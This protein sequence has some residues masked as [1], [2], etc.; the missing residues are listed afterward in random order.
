M[1]ILFLTD[2]FP[3]EVNAPAS[4]T[5]EHCREWVR[6]GNQVT[7]ITCAPNFPT[8][9]VYPGYK[10][11]L[12]QTEMMEGI[13]VIRVWT[14]ITA[15]EG[16]AKRILDYVSYMVAA[17]SAS[18]FV[19]KPDLVIGTSP[20]LFTVMAA[21]AVGFLKRIP[22]VF[23]L[24]DI[25]P[26]SIKAVGAMSDSVVI[27]FFEKIEMFLYRK[28]ARIV[29][30]TNS[31]KQT[32]I[33][34]GVDGG[35]IEVVTNGVDIS[36]FKPSA[37]DGELVRRYG[38]EE[39]FVAGYIGTHGMA[40]ALE[41]ILEAADKIRALPDGGRFRFILLG[42]GARKEVLKEK[43]R[44][45]GLDNVLFIDSV[46]KEEVVRYWS[47]LDVSIIHLK[48]TPLFTTVIPSKLFEC[49]GMGIP[50]LHGVA[51]ESAAIVEHEKCG[52]VFEPENSDELID[53][54][55]RLS[56]EP[57]VYQELQANCLR[58]A[59][60]YDRKVLAAKMLAILEDIQRYAT[61]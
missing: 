41:T 7:V 39:K 28:A 12:W 27:R 40:H 45:M 17:T 33:K 55:V 32:L 53:K 38:L 9:K 18:P 4:R 16:F 56:G 25:W 24:R 5:F 52:L 43:A 35:K 48:K 46:P 2:N 59:A 30:V 31:F 49:M 3:P 26:E 34:R 14:Y 50:V 10:N 51:G 29:S 13:R 37:K 20:L 60:K 6:A 57:G 1:H 42:H 54:L 61:K 11:R 21:W 23:E 15:N 36:R 22:F 58:G 47:L 8:G 44:Q 19:R